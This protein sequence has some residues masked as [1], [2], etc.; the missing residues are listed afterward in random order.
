MRDLDSLT[1]H[2]TSEHIVEI[3]CNMTQNDNPEF[4]R[5]LLSYYLAKMAATMRVKIATKDRGEIP[6]NLYA[7]NLATS[8]HGKGHSTNIIEEQLIHLFREVFFNDTYP[9]VAEQSLAQLA[10]QRGLIHNVDDTTMLEIVKKE[11]DELGKLVFSFDSASGGPAIKQL[12]QK[13]LMSGIGAMNMEIDEIGNN[14]SGN[15]DALGSY[16]EL[17]D[18]GKIKQKLTKNTKENTRSEEIEGRTPA[19]LLL[20]GTPSKLF[21]GGKVEEEFYSLLD[22]GYARRCIFGFSKE[23]KQECVLTPEEVYDAL[24]NTDTK[25]YLQ[26]LAVKFGG[27]ANIVNHNK[28]IMVPKKVSIL[29]IEYRM[30]CEKLARDMGPYQDIAKAEMSHRYFKTLKLAGIYAFIDGEDEVSEDNFYHAMCLVEESGKAFEKILSRDRPYVKLA[31]YLSVIGHEV[32]HVDL[33]EDLVFYRGSAAAK[34]ELVQMAAAWGYKNSIAITRSMTDG[35]EFLGGNTLKEVDPGNMRLSYSSQLSTGYENV[36]V[37]WDDLY[38]LTQT[39]DK[40]WITHHSSNG[41][42]D[43]EHMIQG[44]DMV[45]LDVDGTAT[46]REVQHLLADYNWLVHTTKRHTNA[47]ERFRL[48]MPLNYHMALTNDEFKEFMANIF[49]WLPI[50]VDTQTSQ[51]SRKW[52]THKGQFAYNN[53]GTFLD[54]RPF[55]PK[56]AKND[57]QKTFITTFQSL[58][59]MERWF[60]NGSIKGNRNNQLARYALMMVDLGYDIASIK[61]KVL[62]MNSKLSDKLKVKEIENTIVLSASRKIAK[63]AKK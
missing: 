44:F 11:F 28:V 16:L 63:L 13:L 62:D 10:V 31:K 18:V 29:S 5:I 2:P 36:N 45:V 23:D 57:E 56:T 9:L 7:V 60:L 21:D 27:L 54:A 6:V 40:H 53:G 12:R 35:I 49:E 43:E 52:M 26:D 14:L 59:N 38:L 58:T 1:F 33:A 55:I 48:I 24:I 46:T 4:F 39:P 25:D 3:L 30:Y 20:F 42:R 61:A 34:Q 51:R 19:N 8:G 22:T 15:I 37:S 41:H 47:R 17:Y 32:T 50:K